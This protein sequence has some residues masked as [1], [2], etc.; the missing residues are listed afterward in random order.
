MFTGLTVAACLLLTGEPAPT[1][2]ITPVASL[3]FEI[4]M[5][6]DRAQRPDILELHIYVSKDQGK[7]WDKLPAVPIPADYREDPKLVY[8]APEDGMY[9][10]TVS[11]VS[12]TNHME[13]PPETWKGPIG[14]KVLVKTR[15]SP[16]TLKAERVGER[17]Q[18]KWTINDNYVIKETFRL[19]YQDPIN[20]QWIL[21]PDAPV[22]P[23][24]EWS[25]QAP[26]SAAINVRLTIQDA[27][28][29]LGKGEAF[30]PA[31][32][33][34]V[35]NNEE[36]PWGTDSSSNQNI[37]PIPPGPVS[38]DSFP[39]PAPPGPQPVNPITPVTEQRTVAASSMSVPATQYPVTTGYSGLPQVKI[40]SQPQVQVGFGVDH[41]GPSGVGKVDVYLTTNDGLKWERAATET[42]VRGVENG[43][44][45]GRDSITVKIPRQEIVYGIFLVVKNGAGVGGP[46]P[47]D[48]Q[49][50]PMMRVELDTQ[51]PEAKL[52]QPLPDK[53]HEG[54]LILLWKAVDRNLDDNP[55][56]LEFAEKREGPWALVSNTTTLPNTGAIQPWCT[57]SYAW[58]VPSIAQGRVYLKLTVRDKA[59]NSSEAVTPEPVLIDLSQP[60]V[61]D[62]DLARSGVN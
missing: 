13:N 38:T 18:A 25:F 52:Y 33:T 20:K 3:R 16:I 1:P 50:R 48:G 29:N 12:K 26:P 23:V 44:A 30:V 10:F 32:V 56:T 11:S 58:T 40:V 21:V 51:G 62:V 55:I 59:G 7:H 5:P 9:W 19:E 54:V 4:P 46:P 28:K 61:F 24:G 57:G 34:S 42:P 47:R 8:T 39:P 35:V 27:A 53:G 36:R 6:V 14:Q 41:L 2:E 45:S 15:P 37:K 17:I 31:T 22:V 43:L 60:K 49:D